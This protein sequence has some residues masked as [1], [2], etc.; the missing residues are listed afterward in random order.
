MTPTARSLAHLRK[1]GATAEVVERW[2]PQARK[3]KDLF[4]FIDIVALD[5]MPG[6]L[7]VQTTSAGNVSHRLE[8]I[9]T[10]C[11]FAMERWLE[12]GNRI[13]IHGWA[14]RGPRGKRKVW[15]LTERVVDAAS[16]GAEDASSDERSVGAR[17]ART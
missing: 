12:A 9:E 3:R 6:T 8:K 2:I 17:D 16:R 5:G 11:R 15:T 7:G 1:L 14:K 10:A 4:G 13:V